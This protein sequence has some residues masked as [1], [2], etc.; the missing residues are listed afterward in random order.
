MRPYP[1][2]YRQGRSPGAKC[3]KYRHQGARSE[4]HVAEPAFPAKKGR[5]NQG[6]P[7]NGHALAQGHNCKRCTHLCSFPKRNADP[8]VAIPTDDRP[9]VVAR[10][11]VDQNQLPVLEGLI[12]YR[13]DR[14]SDKAL[15]IERRRYDR[16]KGIFQS[17][18][19]TF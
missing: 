2:C 8:G 9:R 16:E 5:P 15:I 11:V 4:T 10:A 6:S 7:Q 3:H 19:T 18:N 1:P 17:R 12:Q 13:F 14:L